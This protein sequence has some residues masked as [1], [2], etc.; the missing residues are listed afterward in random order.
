MRTKSKTYALKFRR[1][2]EGRTNYKKRL[3]LLISGIPRLVVRKASNSIIA[4]VSEY[5]AKGDK[6]IVSVNSIELKKLG[7][8]YNTGNLPSAYLTGLLLGKKAKEKG[9]K[10]AILDIGLIPSINGSRIYAVLAG[11]VDSG[12]AVPFDKKVLPKEERINGK[13]IAA[14]ASKIKENKEVY[15]HVFSGY[16]KKNA[17]PTQLTKDFQEIKGK[18]VG[19]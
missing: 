11:V 6:I 4:S 7:W 13:H 15:E 19:G 2:R 1:R 3:S 14:Y 8:K 12:I 18:I 9:I 17:D 5:N 16:I 10:K